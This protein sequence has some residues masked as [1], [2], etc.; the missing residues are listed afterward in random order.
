MG[1]EQLSPE[2]KANLEQT[3]LDLNSDNRITRAK[4]EATVDAL[5]AM[6]INKQSEQPSQEE[7]VGGNESLTKD[8]KDLAVA[9]E[10]VQQ[11]IANN[12]TESLTK[13]GK[14]LAVAIEEVQ[15]AITDNNT[16]SLTEDGKALA[17]V[18]NTMSNSNTEDS[19]TAEE[20]A[21]TTDK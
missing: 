4:A 9:I 16:E 10:E 14:D 20:V 5:N 1:A 13:D 2:M 19:M 3:V 12:N 7:F 6:M 21:S 15:K 8:G 17:A 18:M 11:A